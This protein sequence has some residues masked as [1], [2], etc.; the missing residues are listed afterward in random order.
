MQTL[1]FFLLLLL[2]PFKSKPLGTMNPEAP[3]FET[4]PHGHPLHQALGSQDNEAVLKADSTDP[5]VGSL[6]ASPP[7]ILLLSAP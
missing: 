1:L 7:I 3:A 5:A 6:P 4:L 2:T